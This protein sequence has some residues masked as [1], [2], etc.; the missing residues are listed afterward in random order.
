M[1]F[2]LDNNLSPHI[3]EALRILGENAIHLQDKFKPDTN[4]IE[5]LPFIAKNDMALITLDLR[6]TKIPLEVN[7]LKKY[8]IKAFF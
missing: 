3:P 7:L 4:D 6:I 8:N 1:I 2:F 5:W